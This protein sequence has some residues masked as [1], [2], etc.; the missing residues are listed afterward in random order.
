MSIFEVIMIMCFGAAWPAAIYKSY[1]SRTSRG[2]SLHFL[3]IIFLGYIAGLFHKYFYNLD[4]V[5]WLYALNGLMVF[6]DI[7]FYF[8]N[9][10][11]DK[12][13]EDQCAGKISAKL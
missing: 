3:V 12:Q 7:L 10:A 8:R 1:T 9:A 5:V 6:V 13:E 4:W 11:I 2:K